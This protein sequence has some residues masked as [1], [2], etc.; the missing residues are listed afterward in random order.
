MNS[1]LKTTSQTTAKSVKPH[2]LL[3]TKKDG[4]GRGLSVHNNPEPLKSV[5]NK[6][7]NVFVRL[8]PKLTDIWLTS[9]LKEVISFCYVSSQSSKTSEITTATASLKFSIISLIF[10]LNKKPNLYFKFKWIN[11]SSFKLNHFRKQYQISFKTRETFFTA[12]NITQT[13]RIVN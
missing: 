6:I 2:R 1:F 9:T 12:K 13:P 11:G 7:K 4:R 10:K 5:K 3:D 8:L